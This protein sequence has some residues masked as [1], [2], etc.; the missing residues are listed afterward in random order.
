R[1]LAL[2]PHANELDRRFPIT[3]NDLLA[4]G[5]WRRV[6]TWRRFAG[7][8]HARVVHAL[9]AVGLSALRLLIIGRPS[10]RALP[11]APFAR[12]VL[13]DARTLLLDE[14]FA[15]IDRDTT[16]DLMRLLAA[17]HEEGRTVIVVLHDQEM[18]R[19]RFPEALLMAGQAV[20]WGPTESVLTLE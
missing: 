19:A 17:W 7:G 3:A 11:R 20:A 1:D 6:A 18:V 14:P 2:L 5:A 13:H 10:I 8:E 16:E 4:M 15:A 9:E 12:P